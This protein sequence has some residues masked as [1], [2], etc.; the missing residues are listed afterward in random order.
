MGKEGDI[1][2][3]CVPVV[4]PSEGQ[5]DLDPR[6]GE[7]V[8]PGLF[9]RQLHP[10]QSWRFRGAWALPVGIFMIL[11]YRMHYSN[12]DHSVDNRLIYYLIIYV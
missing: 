12:S 8:N 11:V 3:L 7:G 4:W 2:L 5:P 1:R 6:V 10:V 9:P